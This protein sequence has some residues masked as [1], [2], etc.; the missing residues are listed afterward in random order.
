MY[1]VS[2]KFSP[3]NTNEIFEVRTEHSCNLRQN[4]Q[5]FLLLLKSVY[6]GNE[7]ISFLGPKFWNTLPSV[8]KI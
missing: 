8:D 1:N 5:L 6:H 3:P 2:D 4:S 7:S